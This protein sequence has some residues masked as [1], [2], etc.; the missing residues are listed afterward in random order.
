MTNSVPG[1]TYKLPHNA[2]SS[3]CTLSQTLLPRSLVWLS[4]VHLCITTLYRVSCAWIIKA[5][6]SESHSGND[7][8]A[9]PYLEASWDKGWLTPSSYAGSQTIHPTGQN[10][11]A[12]EK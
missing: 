11:E 6:A 9:L 10:T 1:D 3:T 12:L 7:T 4:P 8:A 2:Q 5:T